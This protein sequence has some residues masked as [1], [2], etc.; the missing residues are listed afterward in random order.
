MAGDVR[1]GLTAMPKSL[2]PKYFYDDE[3]CRLFEEITRLPEYY[4]TRAE[5]AL[6]RQH[7]PALM[8]VLRP[9]EIVEL[10]S[11]SSTKTRILLNSQ[12]RSRPVERYVPFDVAPGAIA[13]AAAA[14]STIYP[15]LAVHGIVGDFERHLGR[16][17]PSDGDRVVLFLGSTIGNLHAHE[18]TAFLRETRRLLAPG[19]HFLLGVDQVKDIAVLEAAYND[20]AGVTAAFNR[21]I[22]RA[23]NA[24]L[25]ANFRPEA[26]AHEAFYNTEL[27]RIEMHLRPDQAQTVRLEKLDL[28]VKIAGGESIWTES[29]YKFT[30]EST[31]E[32]LQEAGLALIDWLQDANGLFALAVAIPA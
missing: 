7:A 20:S 16:I 9:R 24:G 12:D 2:P 23:I 22:L 31:T 28:E 15:S 32:I 1:A 29:S 27:A 8:S 17:P 21:N 3:G 26:F 19:D 6:L 11:G 10:G 14:L 4:P 18:R 13:D 25:D 30:R 5:A